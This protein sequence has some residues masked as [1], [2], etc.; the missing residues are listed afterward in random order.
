MYHTVPKLESLICC[1]TADLSWRIKDLSL[2][3][4]LPNLSYLNLSY[5]L[6][7]SISSIPIKLPLKDLKIDTN[8]LISLEGIE[9]FPNLKCLSAENNNIRDIQSLNKLAKLQWINLSC[10]NISDLRGIR[11]LQRLWGLH[12]FDNEITNIT[13][14]EHNFNL[15]FLDLGQN[16]I[17]TIEGFPHLLELEQL[18]LSDNKIEGIFSPGP[19]SVWTN[20]GLPNLSILDLSRNNITLID[21]TIRLEK[22]KS[23]SFDSNELIS[24]DGLQELST[25]QSLHAINNSLDDA[26][27]LDSILELDNLELVVLDG[28]KVLDNLP[29]GVVAVGWKAIRDRLR[30]G[31][32]V[33]FNEVKILLLGNPNVGKSWL[34]EYLETKAVPQNKESTNG[35]QYKELR[36]GENKINLHFWDFGGQEYFHATHRLFFSPGG[37]HIVLW[38]KEDIQ[39]D[40]AQPDLC[41]DLSYWIRSVERLV[42]NEIKNKIDLIIVENKIDLNNFILTPINQPAYITKY[43]TLNIEFTGISITALKRLN[44]FTEILEERCEKLVDTQ[45]SSYV[46]YY[47]EI[48]NSPFDCIAINTIA[49]S[50]Q[51]L[52][53]VKTAMEV[54]TN[55]GILLYFPGIIPDK[56]FI[57]PQVLLDLLYKNILGEHNCTEITKSE[58]EQK[59]DGNSLG[60]QPQE[61]INLLLHFDLVFQITECPDIY[62]IPQYLKPPHELV[63]FFKQHQFLFP[64]VFIESDNYMMNSVMLRIFSEYG[65]YVQ[66]KDVKQYLFWKDGIVIEKDGMILMI[67][68]DRIMQRIELYPDVKNSNFQLQKEITNYILSNPPDK[69]KKAIPL[70]DEEINWSSDCFSVYISLD[71]TFYTSWSNLIEHV[72]NDILQIK[73]SSVPQSNNDAEFCIQSKT[74]SVFD[75]NKFLPRKSKGQMKNIF[76][77]YSKEDLAMVNKFQEHLSA[78]KLDGK[79]ATWYCTELSAGSEWNFE[80]QK[81]FEA[82]DIVCFMISPNFMKTKYIHEY[83]IQK[84][85]KRK[86][87]NPDF[88]IIPIILDFCRWKTTYNNLE[89]FCALPYTAKPI[90]DFA[91]QNMAWYIVQE[92]LRLIIENKV[93]N[94]GDAL[95]NSE[96]LPKDLKQIFERI[97][98]RKVDF[99]AN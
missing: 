46:K 98:E 19:K 12:L 16:Y 54:F 65:K 80:I 10:N 74:V 78:L 99:N 75:F 8:K 56:V 23:I 38:S 22:I 84:A 14:L 72:N 62:F 73:I 66:G 97:I 25:L 44:N 7:E 37:L 1:G 76:I 77:S 34:L 5:N 42:P 43:P 13:S 96:D 26:K 9:R 94:K 39:R 90:A 47:N 32:L 67:N 4:E 63:N 70:Q 21:G 28:N 48:R 15:R 82:A 64:D 11:Y 71:G 40:D 50:V 55:M 59:I 81:H 45:P 31:N 18:S 61:V 69:Q 2:L 53:T 35:I 95:Y 86:S 85:F 89:D 51:E 24:L 83:E 3:A 68:F 79:V 20:A 41:F 87:K 49:E 88:L 29:E 57:K 33:P 27:S 60:I 30:S 17:K 92:C 91:N 52:G 58:I 6:I 36:I 93:S